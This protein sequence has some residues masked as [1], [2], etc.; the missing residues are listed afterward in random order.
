[1]GW[2]AFPSLGKVYRKVFC[3]GE[4]YSRVIGLAV[5]FMNHFYILAGR[6]T[7]MITH[8]GNLEDSVLVRRKSI[9]FVP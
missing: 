9:Q 6:A 8:T 5:K 7:T 4:L 1:M 3:R 2:T